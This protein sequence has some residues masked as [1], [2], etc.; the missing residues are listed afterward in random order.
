MS[1]RKKYHRR[2]RHL[3]KASNWQRLPKK[4]PGKVGHGPTGT[5]THI[6]PP[7]EIMTKQERRKV[8]KA[9][10]LVARQKAKIK[11]KFGIKS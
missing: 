11:R 7:S 5:T 8:N 4:S 10:A 9:K 3:A 1:D 2:E 6:T